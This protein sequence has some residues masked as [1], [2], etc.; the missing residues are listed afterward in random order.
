[1]T[2]EPPR[3]PAPLH[4]GDR[5]AIIAPSSPFE[6]ACLEQ[7]VH[8]LRSA[9]FAPTWDDALMDRWRYLA[10]TDEERARCLQQAL[11][12][13]EVRGV[14]CAR[15]GYG[16]ARLI[17]LLDLEAL[18]PHCKVFVGF[19]DV[20]ALHLLFRRH[21]G[22]V[23]F[24]GPMMAGEHARGGFDPESVDS[25]LRNVT[26]A[27]IPPPI[28]GGAEARC[29]RGGRAEGPIVGG[30]LSLLSHSLGTPWEIDT[31]DALLLVEDV[32]EAPYRIDRMLTH[33]RQAGKL[34]GIRGLVVGRM[35]D[36]RPRPCSDYTVD[37]VLAE[38]LEDLGVPVVTGFPLTHDQPNL[39]V[40]LGTRM[41]LEADDLW[42][43]PLEAPTRAPTPAG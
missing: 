5:V 7:G 13:P 8:F 29:L 10:G 36:C 41:R 40:A 37:D 11:L 20:T 34:S 6:A 17:P 38:C 15:G 3:R 14:F 27:E 18:R 24:H 21:L 26:R 9:G 39:T 43:V 28:E 4:P 1:M 12:D 35:L 22:W 23:T 30:N 2:L 25:L 16:C 42:L 19:S 31:R 33:L 32:H